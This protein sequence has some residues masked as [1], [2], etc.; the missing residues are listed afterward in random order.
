MSWWERDEGYHFL[1]MNKVKVK[2]INLHLFPFLIPEKNP[3]A[4]TYLGSK[5][6]ES[7]GAF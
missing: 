6:L 3:K 7:K 5:Q 2:E 1:R 4:I